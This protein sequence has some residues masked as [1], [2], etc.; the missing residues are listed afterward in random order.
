[1]KHGFQRYIVR[2]EILSAFHAQVEYISGEQYVIP[3][4][5][6]GLIAHR[7]TDTQT[8]KSENSISSS[9]TPFTWWI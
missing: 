7:H 6:T 3:L 4:L 5:K 9:F 2:T 8:H 1:M